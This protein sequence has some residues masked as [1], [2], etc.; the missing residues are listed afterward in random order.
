MN[1]KEILHALES[2]REKF[3]DL[4][5]GFSPE[6]LEQPGVAG[7]WSIKDIIAH[8]SMWEGELVRML[9]QAKR[10]ETPSTAQFRGAPVDT[11]NAQ[12]FKLAKDRP[13]ERILEDFHA[14]RNQTMHR[15]EDFSEHDL[16]DPKRYSW[17]KGKALWERIADDSFAHESEHA[18]DV[19][20]WLARQS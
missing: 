7:D 11:V 15:V 16:T 3:L 10:G 19:Q 6:E 14:V 9:W 18:A 5:E 4:I 17:S 1:K 2:E 13:L 20:A 12:W 8:L